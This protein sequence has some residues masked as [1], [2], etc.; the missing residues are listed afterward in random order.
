MQRNLLTFILILTPVMAMAHPGHDAGF[1]GGVTHPI[2]GADHVLAM[3]AVGLW[4]ALTGGRALWA[5]PMAFVAAM[6]AGGMLGA[7]GLPFPAV[8]PM[9]LASIIVLGVAA[10]CALRLPLAVAIAGIAVFGLAHGHAHGAEGG[11][12]GA[13]LAGFT[14]ATAAL[15]AAGLVLGLALLRFGQSR[16]ARGVGVAVALGGLGLAVAG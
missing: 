10:A 14:L 4:A 8:E 6:V 15:H 9:I 11:G 5:M 12:S 16:L 1:V 7:Q 13:F 2:G 3:V